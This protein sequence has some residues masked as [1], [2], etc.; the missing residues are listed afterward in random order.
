[1]KVIPV[2]KKRYVQVLTRTEYRNQC[3]SA[4]VKGPQEVT[5]SGGPEQEGM[6]LKPAVC[7]LGRWPAGLA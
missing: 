7:S 5:K 6:L 1:V 3:Y 4:Q 2:P